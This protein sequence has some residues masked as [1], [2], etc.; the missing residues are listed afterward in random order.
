MNGDFPGG[1]TSMPFPV[2]GARFVIS[3]SVGKA[4]C[5]PGWNWR[6][7]PLPDYDLWYALSGR[8]N[9]QIGDRTYPIGKGSCFIL[10]PGDC[11]RAD[12]DAVERL[13]VIYVHFEIRNASDGTAFV[14]DPLPARHTAISEAHSFEPLLER[15]VELAQHPDDWYLEEFDLL[16][17][18]VFLRLYREELELERRR[19]PEK[20]TARKQRRLV[21]QVTALLRENPG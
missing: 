6:P 12:Q 3:G 19:E 9:M 7:Q 21:A 1:V 18:Q 14:P 5:E 20:N 16:M 13:R 15:I 11:P 10:R 8:G 17:K 4:R 2:A